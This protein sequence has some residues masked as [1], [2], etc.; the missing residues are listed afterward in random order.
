MVLTG[1][2]R[3]S[4]LTRLRSRASAGVILQTRSGALGSP[5]MADKVLINLATVATPMWEW[6]GDGPH[7]VFSY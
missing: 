6:L 4:G 5:V 2:P 3:E 7:T 1:P